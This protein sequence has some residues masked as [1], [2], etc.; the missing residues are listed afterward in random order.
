M[1]VVELPS[2]AVAGERLLAQMPDGGYVAFDV[3]H[4]LPAGRRVAIR[5]REA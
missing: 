4:V 5:V 1:M 3:P 2:C